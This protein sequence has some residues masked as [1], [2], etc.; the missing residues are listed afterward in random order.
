M[1]QRASWGRMQRIYPIV[2]PMTLR[3]A[4]WRQFTGRFRYWWFLVLYDTF[5]FLDILADF[6]GSNNDVELKAIKIFCWSLVSETNQLVWMNI[7]SAIQC[8]TCKKNSQYNDS[9]LTIQILHRFPC[10]GTNF[11]NIHVTCLKSSS[12]I[13]LGA[14]LNWYCKLHCIWLYYFITN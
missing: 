14:V 3:S 4:D 1:L 5:T 6:Q 9:W 13:L 10:T 2:W 11:I 12:S 8:K 7:S